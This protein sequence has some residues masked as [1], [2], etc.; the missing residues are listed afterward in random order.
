MG[1]MPCAH[2]QLA[3]VDVAALGQLINQVEALEAQLLQAQSQF[4]SMTGPRGMERLLTGQL[5]NYLPLIGSR[6]RRP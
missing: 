3:V 2:A 1:A 6:S 5:R 4:E